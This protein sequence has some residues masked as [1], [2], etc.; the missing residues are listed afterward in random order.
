MRHKERDT[1]IRATRSSW[2]GDFVI[3][4]EVSSRGNVRVSS[5]VRNDFNFIMLVSFSGV[6]L[7]RKRPVYR[8]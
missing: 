3:N 8:V 1:L 4:C 7:L 5:R 6:T 2:F